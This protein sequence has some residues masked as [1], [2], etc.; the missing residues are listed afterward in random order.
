MNFEQQVENIYI[1]NY[2]YFQVVI[3]RI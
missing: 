1:N 2:S 3:L